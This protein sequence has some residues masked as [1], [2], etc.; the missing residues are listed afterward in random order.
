[1]NCFGCKLAN[2]Q[3][4]VY[5]IYEDEY[6]CCILDHQPYNEGHV[7]ILPK[8]HVRYFDDLD[9]ETEKS[10][11]KAIKFL[12]KGIKQLFEP[13]GITIC[14]NGGDFDDL[15][16]FHLH[17]VPRYKGQNFAEF[18]VEDDVKIEKEEKLRL[19]QQ[20]MKEWILIEGV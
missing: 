17:L 1:M 9:D 8:N 6:V 15:N 19:T 12:S 16:H 11:M 7:L 18:Y 10:L 20:K 13:D 2:Q 5:V 3:E 14:Q 4:K